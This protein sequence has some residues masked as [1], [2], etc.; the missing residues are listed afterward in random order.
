MPEGLHCEG[1]ALHSLLG[2]LLWDKIYQVAA[3]HSVNK[4]R[5]TSRI[6]ALMSGGVPD[7]PFPWTGT[8]TTSM[9]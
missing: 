4:L 5:C 8:L 9:K 7:K 2:L 1:A 6:A 3:F